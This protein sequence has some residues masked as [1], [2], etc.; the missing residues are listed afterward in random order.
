MN[1]GSCGL[2]QERFLQGECAFALAFSG[3]FK[4]NLKHPRSKVAG[5]AK[6][7]ML[8]GSTQVSAALNKLLCHASDASAM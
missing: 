2:L 8:P 4:A 6:P 5:L 1:G 3:Q 7:A